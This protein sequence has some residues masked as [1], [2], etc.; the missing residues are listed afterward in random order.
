MQDVFTCPEPVM[1]QLCKLYRVH[2][3]PIGTKRTRDIAEKVIR[4]LPQFNNFY[5]ENYQVSPII[6]KVV[7]TSIAIFIPFV[8]PLNKRV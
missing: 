8:C 2:N 5:T 1:R 6:F 3:I 4:E 7:M